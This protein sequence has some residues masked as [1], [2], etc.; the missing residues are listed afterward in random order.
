MRSRRSVPAFAAWLIALVPVFAG[1]H[2]LLEPHEWCAE[3]LAL[4]HG[5]PTVPHSHDSDEHGGQFEPPPSGDSERK[6]APDSPHH[7]PCEILL[8]SRSDAA[9]LVEPVAVA[10]APIHFTDSR[11][12]FAQETP[13]RAVPLLRLAPKTS[14]PSP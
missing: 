1:L 9:A 4:E 14:P 6:N 2:C 13:R 10:A 11:T 7:D 12:P 5:D 3:H 8:L